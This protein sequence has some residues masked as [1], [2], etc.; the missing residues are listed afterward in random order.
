MIVGYYSMLLGVQ[1]ITTVS[2]ALKRAACIAKRDT[3]LRKSFG[4]SFKQLPGSFL[5]LNWYLRLELNMSYIMTLTFSSKP[6]VCV[7]S[8]G[9]AMG[10]LSQL[11]AKCAEWAIW[12]VH[13]AVQVLPVT[14]G[15]IT[16]P[17]FVSASR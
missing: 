4:S 13:K 7:R 12:K 17:S 2:V 6:K 1:V 14:P 10:K 9:E 15:V 5:V 11:D 8:P 16:S 3:T